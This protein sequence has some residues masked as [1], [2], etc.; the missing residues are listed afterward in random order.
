MSAIPEIRSIIENG[1]SDVLTL[2]SSVGFILTVKVPPE[3][4]NHRGPSA[5]GLRMTTPITDYLLKI[6]ILQVVTTQLAAIYDEKHERHNKLT[7][8]VTVFFNEAKLQQKLWS[9]SI[10]GGKPPVCPNVYGISY[11]CGS[12]LFNA[13]DTTSFSSEFVLKYSATYDY[14]KRCHNSGLTIGAILMEYIPKSQTLHEI[15]NGDDMTKSNIACINAGAQ[16]VRLFLDHAII[17]CD[18][19]TSNVIVGESGMAYVI[20]FASVINLNL[21]TDPRL[22]S[23]KLFRL[24]VKQ[25]MS[26]RN[27][28]SKSPINGALIEEIFN[29]L[30]DC[31]MEMSRSDQMQILRGILQERGLWEDVMDKYI[32]MSTTIRV[33]S[34]TPKYEI[35]EPS[36]GLIK[37]LN[38]SNGK[39]SL[40]FSREPPDVPRNWI[41]QEQQ[42][43]W[44]QQW[45]QQERQQRQAQ[46]LQYPDIP[47]DVYTYGNKRSATTQDTTRDNKYA[48]GITKNKRPKNKRKKTRFKKRR[49]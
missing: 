41:A 29:N 46:L 16:V 33:S 25:Q 49:R 44:R 18:L 36:A 8:R 43:Q 34:S 24:R 23:I 37:E 9:D 38:M 39:H 22:D 47:T 4:A 2:E 6:A 21:N 11:D 40:G 48:K 5:S 26:E 27:S 30:K 17:H 3:N 15:I 28:R 10:K 31:E 7:E 19:H 1:V 42:Q 45:L 12:N 32:E 14:L 35:P 13:D 20:D